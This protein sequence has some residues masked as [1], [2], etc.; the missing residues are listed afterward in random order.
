MKVRYEIDLTLVHDLPIADVERIYYTVTGKGGSKNAGIDQKLSIAVLYIWKEIGRYRFGGD[1]K[2][3]TVKK[4]FNLRKSVGDEFI[5]MHRMNYLT[6]RTLQDVYDWLDDKNRLTYNVK[7]YWKKI[8]RT[9]DK[10]MKLHMAQTDK[11]SW[12]TVQ[13]HV[14]LASDQV[15]PFIPQLEVAVRDYLIQH[16]KEMLAE[17]QKD[18]IAMLAKLHTGL[19]FCA[20]LRN[21]RLNFFRDIVK[22]Y[23][24]DFTPDFTYA[25]ITSIGR[26]FVSMFEQLGVKFSK[27]K[28]DDYVLKG[29]NV[30]N[31]LRVES[32]WNRIVAVVTND[33]LMD[34][35]AIKAI[36]LNP[37]VK[38]DYEA[39]VA[40][41]EEKQLEIALGDLGEKYKVSSL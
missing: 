10:Y 7:G 31:S 11:V 40:Q 30:E 39:K 36:N 18:D 5:H 32:A 8:E 28:D 37:V 2:K 33:E 6:Y 35:M 25:D 15:M 4:F 13:D 19:M 29:V 27:D 3:M 22:R 23:G 1:G 26:N 24:V 9:F 14:R 21:T 41:A 34:E 17:G 16:R 12:D 38:A 20:A